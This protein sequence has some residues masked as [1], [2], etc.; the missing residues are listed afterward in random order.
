MPHAIVSILRALKYK[1]VFSLPVNTVL[2]RLHFLCFTLLSIP[3]GLRV[4]T[5]TGSGTGTVSA[6]LL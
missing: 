3:E 6:S 2:L 4:R 1:L 5:Y